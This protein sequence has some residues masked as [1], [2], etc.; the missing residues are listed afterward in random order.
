[1]TGF[2][3]LLIFGGAEKLRLASADVV[4]AEAGIPAQVCMTLEP[5]ILPLLQDTPG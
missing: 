1:M 4:S 2:P 5:G 3:L